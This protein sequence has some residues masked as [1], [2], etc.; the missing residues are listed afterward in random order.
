MP[1]YPACLGADDG[2]ADSGT[3]DRA[4]LAYGRRVHV[5]GATIR[6]I[7]R[8]EV[9]RYRSHGIDL[10]MYEGVQ[11]VCGS[12]G[13]VLTAYR[14]R[15]FRGLRPRRCRL[16]RTEHMAAKGDHIFGALLRAG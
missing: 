8:R 3:G 7:G 5:R 12:D 9:A 1:N 6:A 14:N 13:A 2:A 15:D 11:V 10:A 16:R 4:A